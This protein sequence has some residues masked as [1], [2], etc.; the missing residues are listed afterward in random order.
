MALHILATNDV[1]Q[2]SIADG[3]LDDE[4]Y[5]KG[6]AFMV[7]VEYGYRPEADA[8]EA[9]STTHFPRSLPLLVRVL[10]LNH[11]GCMY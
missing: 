1:V 10:I 11:N 6:R 9:N 2:T 8:E 3:D 5:E 4:A 7:R